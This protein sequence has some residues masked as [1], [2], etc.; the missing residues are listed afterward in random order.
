[1]S[2][3]LPT[4]KPTAF[5]LL[6]LLFVLAVLAMLSS[7]ALP[8]V[9][10]MLAKAEHRAAADSLHA[11]LS[12]LRLKAIQTGRSHSFRFVPG[13]GIFELRAESIDEVGQLDF[14][15]VDNLAGGEMDKSL[16]QYGSEDGSQNPGSENSSLADW[17]GANTLTEPLDDSGEYSTGSDSLTGDQVERLQL[18]G[19]F[20]IISSLEEET[21]SA[22]EFVSNSTVDSQAERGEE[23][24]VMGELLDASLTD[25]STAAQWSAPILFFP[26]GRARDAR[27]FVVAPSGYFIELTVVGISGKVRVGNRRR[28]PEGA[29]RLDLPANNQL[30]L[31]RI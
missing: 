16:E 2:T 30:E 24:N 20:R 13:S 25:D 18:T 17:A 7:V 5:T 8:R 6:E 9:E 15:A 14:A 21:T 22:G 1:V 27:L 10:R 19:Q 31:T 29:S 28:P 12:Q 23:E 26:D 4:G 11:A 3:A